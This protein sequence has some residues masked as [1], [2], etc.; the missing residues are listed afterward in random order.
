MG[1]LPEILNLNDNCY[2]CGACAAICR[3]NCIT[4]TEDDAGFLRPS[5]NGEK[6]ILCHAC[7]RVCPAFHRFEEDQ[8]V[9][10][11]GAR[12]S[13][14]ELL[15]NSS[16]GGIFGLLANQVLARNGIVVG[17]VF[18]D[19]MMVKHV[20]ISS[21]DDL[22]R[23]RSSKYVQSSVGCEIYGCVKRA[24]ME[25]RDVLFSGTACQVAALRS[26]LGNL[27]KTKS[28]LLV[29]VVCH[30]VPSSK[31]WRMWK[32]WLEG[33]A[34]SRLISATFRDKS[35]GWSSYSVIYRFAN[36]RRIKHL[37]SDDW[38]M[39]AFLH[40]DALRPSCY[41]CRAKLHC[42]ADLTLGDYWGIWQ[43]HSHVRWGNGISA[44]IVRS[45]KGAKAI[46]DLQPAMNSFAADYND[47]VKGNPALATS[48]SRGK[49][50]DEFHAMLVDG[51]E[52]EEIMRR[53]PYK[54][55]LL[56][57]MLSV[58]GVLRSKLNI[59]FESD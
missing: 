54:R 35:T 16:S 58:A 25:N 19:T 31:L 30:G 12:A 4:M 28:L 9:D 37:G 52:V 45:K 41:S 17:A 39:K 55:P 47:V 7:D 57:R 3:K 6:C 11:Y 34:A 59:L 29:E 14:D 42:G 8:F 18:D 53:F 48:V 44:V 23:A 43:S 1:N 33:Q 32:D 56:H 49:N 22:D 51:V 13:G 5:I 20:V 24:L 46:R 36:G 38:Y 15:R 27:S 50:Y 10:V 26:Y 21:Y 40:D 2:G